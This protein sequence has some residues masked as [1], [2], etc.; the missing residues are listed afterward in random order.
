MPEVTGIIERKTSAMRNTRNGSVEVFSL[1]INGEW[2]GC[3][4]KKLPAGAEEGANISFS[5]D[6]NG[7]YKNLNATTVTVVSAAA[8]PPAG[9]SAPARG[10]AGDDRQRVIVYQSA[11]N[12]AIEAFAAMSAADAI[13]LPTKK[14]DKYDAAMAFIVELTDRF[15]VDAMAVYTG[16]LTITDPLDNPTIPVEDED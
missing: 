6:Q 1:Q 8:A 4:F 10:N 12:A 13:A 7:E 15:H 14:G 3:G 16:D 5:Y 11:R 2:Y 9:G